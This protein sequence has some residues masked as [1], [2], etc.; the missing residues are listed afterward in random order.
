MS[1]P[2]HVPPS[3]APWKSLALTFLVLALGCSKTD[4]A[5][6]TDETKAASKKDDEAAPEKSAKKDKK[7]K[8]KADDEEAAPEKPAKKKVEVAMPDR[9][10][11]P[12]LAEWNAATDAKVA[13]NDCNCEVRAVREWARVSCRK[14]SPGGG[15]PTGVAVERGKTKDTFV[16]ASKSVASIV[17]PLLPGTDLEA[18][19]SWSD[20]V[21]AVRVAWPKDHEKP[22]SF[23]HFTKTD[24]PPQKPL[25]VATCE[26]HKKQG[27][28]KCDDSDE[29]WTITNQNP[30]CEQSYPK[31]CEK[32]I[33]CARGEPGAMPHCPSDHQLMYPG[34]YCL[35]KCKSAK[36]CDK[37]E[38]CE[39]TPMDEKTKVCM[40]VSE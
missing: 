32:L 8:D 37:G 22:E 1:S 5:E 18:K 15:D 36:D 9:T 12:T 38:T 34:N 10:K 39:P 6:K 30:W 24:D 27:G 35:K 16:F 31:D 4:K 14:K 13:G 33:G 17:T 11:V 28:K 20:V 40:G 21:Y 25:G 29:N 23:V 2:T 7:A 19:F 3:A 26:C